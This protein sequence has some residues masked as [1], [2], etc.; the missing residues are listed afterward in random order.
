MLRDRYDNPVSTA[1][2]AARDAYVEGVDAFL[3]ALPAPE[4]R[5]DAALA[6]DPGF[7]LAHAGRARALQVAGRVPE[8]REAMAAALALAP[9]LTAREAA[10]LSVMDALIVGRGAEA[11]EAAR[12]HVLAHPRDV[13]IA[14]TCM[15]V[16][17]LIGFSGLPGREAEQLAYA[18]ALAPAYGEDWWFL[19]MLAFARCE[20][21]Q[22]ERASDEIDRSLAMQQIGRASCRERVSFTV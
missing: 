14:Q 4:A 7:A 22:L 6:A 1:S 17:G 2:P 3:A 18:E 16:F 20:V 8:A 12:A 10:H 11:R 9:G 21:G 19:S 13:M 5:F 15:S